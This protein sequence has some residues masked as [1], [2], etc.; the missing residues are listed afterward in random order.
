MAN[1]LIWLWAMVACS[2]I[3]RIPAPDPAPSLLPP[4]VA[5]AQYLRGQILA[6][7]GDLD[8]AEYSLS[9]ARIFDANEP[10]ILMALGSVKMT[11]GDV[12][13]ARA[14]FSDAVKLDPSDAG[15]WFEHGRIEMAFGDKVLGRT[16]LRKSLTLGGAWPAR[17]MLISDALRV[18]GNSNMPDDLVVWIDQ[19]VDDPVEL[20]RRGELRL[21][22]GDASGAV[23]DLLA[24]LDRV[25]HDVSL[26]PSLVRAATISREIS[27]VLMHA[28]AV[29]QSDPNAK[30]Y[31]LLLGRLSSLIADHEYI[32]FA[33][34]NAD[35]LGVQL[36]QADQVILSS[37]KSVHRSAKT[38][39]IDEP[40]VYPETA[41]GRALMLI[42][43]E[44]WVEAKETVE[45]AL[46]SNVDDPNML[47]MLA[48]I[49]LEADGSKAA[50]PAV[51]K[52]I[53]VAEDYGPG[54]N[55][56]AWVHAEN[57]TRLA[58]AEAFSLQALRHQP[59]I[60]GYWDTLGW[61]LIR[62][63]DC[64]R[65]LP[66]LDRAVRLNPNDD[67]VRARRDSCRSSIGSTHQ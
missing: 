53:H 19:P 22:A 27:S 8:G 46:L 18:E 40:T 11:R 29:V 32:I 25:R 9:R 51:E 36:S 4:T 5:R 21:V 24:A 57:G 26:V 10:R 33:L 59:H 15:A 50:V 45:Q 13:G 30:G 16:A 58:E 62:Q 28:D 35:L 1:G 64:H 54:L 34:E 12:N 7:A 52:L 41:L 37:A 42:D 31:W 20:R 63:G 65:A 66:I 43:E 47:Y 61:V 3:H 55:L 6:A 17:A 39:S 23:T 60:G 2:P 44:R 56:W 38:T 48:Q 14:L 67:A 49:T